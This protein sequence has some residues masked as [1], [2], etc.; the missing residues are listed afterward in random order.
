MSSGK[1]PASKASEELKDSKSTKSE[2][3]AAASDLA[4]AKKQGT[5]KK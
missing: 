1:K 5:K 4:H 2:K 3:S